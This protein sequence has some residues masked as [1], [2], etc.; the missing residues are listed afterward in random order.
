MILR[1]GR[2]LWRV[3]ALN[4]RWAGLGGGRA[5]RGFFDL[6][7]FCSLAALIVFSL[8]LSPFVS[9]IS[10]RST[11][12]IAHQTL[13]AV[14]DPGRV[15]AAQVLVDDKYLEMNRRRILTMAL[16]M[17]YLTRRLMR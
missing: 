6:A 10:S 17:R 7:A 4:C 9:V 15:F 14:P 13:E 3:T 12:G 5:W 16:C 11:V 1:R 2:S 8:I